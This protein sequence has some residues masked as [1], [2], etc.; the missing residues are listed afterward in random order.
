MGRYMYFRL[1]VSPA[2]ITAAKR[3]AMVQS[4]TNEVE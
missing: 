4:D 2:G 1:A 3:L